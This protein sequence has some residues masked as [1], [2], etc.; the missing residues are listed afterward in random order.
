MCNSC[1]IKHFFSCDI[2]SYSRSGNRSEWRHNYGSIITREKK[3]ESQVATTPPVTRSQRNY[4]VSRSPL[5]MKQEKIFS[6][7]CVICT[8]PPIQKWMEVRV[9]ETSL[10]FNTTPFNNCRLKKKPLT[11]TLVSQRNFRGDFLLLLWSINNEKILES[12]VRSSSLMFCFHASL[13]LLSVLHRISSFTLF[14]HQ[15]V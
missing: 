6:S 1:K 8:P 15:H 10:P 11:G 7:T 14:T 13:T 4:C 12:P 5:R 3:S 9:L 2:Y